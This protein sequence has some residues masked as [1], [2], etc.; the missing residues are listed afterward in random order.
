MKRAARRCLAA[1]VC[2]V[3]A[4]PAS[5]ADEVRRATLP[6]VYASCTAGSADPTRIAVRATAK[7]PVVDF[8]RAGTPPQET[9]DANL[10][11]VSR[12][13]F[14]TLKIGDTLIE[15]QGHATDRALVG[16]LSD[17]RGAHPIDLPAI[18]DGHRRCRRGA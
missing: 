12:R 6:L 10:A 17:E 11:F 5:G 2:S 9:R 7:G 8:E 16:M 1:L 18:A 14:F 4:A 15:F 13:L 3:A